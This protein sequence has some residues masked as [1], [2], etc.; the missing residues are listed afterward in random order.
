[1]EKFNWRRNKSNSLSKYKDYNNMHQPLK[2]INEEV[3]EMNCL[4]GKYSIQS[5]ETVLTNSQE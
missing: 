1:M 2:T 4:S 5:E 3:N